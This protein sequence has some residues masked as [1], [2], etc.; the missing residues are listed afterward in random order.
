MRIEDQLSKTISIKEIWRDCTICIESFRFNKLPCDN[1]LVT[2]DI[3]SDK[4]NSIK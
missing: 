4:S 2:P 1:C 3:C